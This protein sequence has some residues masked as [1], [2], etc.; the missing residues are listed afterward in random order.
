M[1][2]SNLRLV[3][4]FVVAFPF[5]VLSCMAPDL[6]DPAPEMEM[7][8]SEEV[9]HTMGLMEEVDLMVLSALQHDLTQQKITP[10][11]DVSS[12]PGSIFQHDEKNNRVR[13]DYGDGCASG[14]GVVKKG[15]VTIDY[16]DEFLIKGSK[17]II[18]FEN[19]SL[20]GHQLKGSRLLENL[21]FE[22]NSRSLQISS[23]T[24]DFKVTSQSGK[25]YNVNQDYIRSLHLSTDKEGFRIYLEGY[26]NLSSYNDEKTSFEIIHPMV[27]L[28]ECMNSGLSI[29]SKGS[30][31][32]KGEKD[33]Q[34]L[35]TFN[36]ERCSTTP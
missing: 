14:R 33:L 29:P 31:Q 28:Q 16:T 11:P 1:E 18:G 21:G 23:V 10:L 26:G 22:I 3:N 4:W 7:I 2:T 15:I 9:A 27:Y 6:E 36:S 13:I 5:L 34:V 24:N 25:T 17:V 35:I 12:C 19:F 32:L 8:S 30:M 20:N